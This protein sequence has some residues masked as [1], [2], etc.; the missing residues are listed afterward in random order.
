MAIGADDRITQDFMSDGTHEDTE[1][2]YT[3]G[4]YLP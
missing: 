3:E 4:P 1:A 2:I